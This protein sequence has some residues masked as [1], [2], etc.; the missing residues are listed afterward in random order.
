MVS[1]V[2]GHVVGLW[3]LIKKQFTLLELDPHPE[4]IRLR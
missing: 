3:S 4:R 2:V 1:I